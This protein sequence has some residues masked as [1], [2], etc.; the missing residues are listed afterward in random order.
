MKELT[1]KFYDIIEQ[2]KKKN[3]NL[4]DF[5]NIKM[6]KDYVELMQKIQKL[7]GELQKFIDLNFS[8]IKNITYSLKLL[9]K[10]KSILHRESIASKLDEKHET[11]L[12]N[13]G[14]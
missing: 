1:E 2:F 13:Y 8:K 3:H 10:F 9:E 5:E 4:L 12:Y 14:L 6:E 7:D 11:I